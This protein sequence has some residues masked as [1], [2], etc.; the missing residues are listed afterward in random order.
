[1]G[2]SYAWRHYR[3]VSSLSNETRTAYASVFFREAANWFST[4]NIP[5]L[6]RCTSSLTTRKVGVRSFSHDKKGFT[7]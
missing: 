1:M 5:I 2:E 3:E 4:Y 7:S 6:Y